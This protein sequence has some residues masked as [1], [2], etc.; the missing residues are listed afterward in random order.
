MEKIFLFDPLQHHGWFIIYE[1]QLNDYPQNYFPHELFYHSMLLYPKK[2]S[3]KIKIN[4]N[5]DY[6]I[7]LN[8]ILLSVEKKLNRSYKPKNIYQLKAYLSEIMMLPV[9]Y[10][11]AVEKKGIFKGNSFKLAKSHFSKNEWKIIEIA[12]NIRQEWNYELNKIQ[13]IMLTK[14]NK[15]IRKIAKIFFSPKVKINLNEDVK[16]FFNAIKNKN[17][18]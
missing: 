13:K 3:F 1:S 15:Y 9:L 4:P 16:I 17:L 10:L 11:Q 12:T 5:I 2:K 14:P 6:V 18:C 8:N 7:P